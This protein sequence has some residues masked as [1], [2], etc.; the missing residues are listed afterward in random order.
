MIRSRSESIVGHVLLVIAA[1]IAIYPFLAIIGQALR[2]AP[3]SHA[4]GVTLENFVSAWS[5]GG[6]STS[7]LSSAF[8]AVVV[9]IITGV[10]GMLAGY[11]LSVLRL[12]WR[13]AIMG[14]LLVGLVLPSEAR[15]VPLYHMMQDLHLL[16]TYWAL[17][18]P[19]V[20]SSFSLATFWMANFFSSLPASLAEAASIDGAGSWRTLRHVY[21]PIGMNALATLSCLVFLYT[22][23]EFMLALVLVP[24]N[25]TVQTAPLSLSFFA[26][27][28]RNIEP[29]V[30]AAAAVLVALPV[31]IAYAFLQRRFMSGL[32]EGAIKE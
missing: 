32:L 27:N 25:Q 20:A 9:V 13:G 21:A 12:R 2:P 10:V 5:R 4:V 19:Q 28:E 6:F 3:G 8:V 16:N 18:L 29:E 30:I 31:I 14:I 7:L 1:L 24:Q 22:W 11:G 26:G 17:I 23:N 15:I